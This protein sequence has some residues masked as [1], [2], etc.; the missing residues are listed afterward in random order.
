MECPHCFKSVHIQLDSGSEFGT[1]V[2][3]RVTTISCG[4]DGDSSFVFEKTVCPACTR[5]MFAMTIYT[6]RYNH[7]ASLHPADYDIHR[8]Q[9]W[10]RSS[11][12]PPVP[13]EVPDEYK[14]DYLEACLILNDSPRASAALSRGCLQL[15]LREK[16]GAEGKDLYNQIGWVLDNSN[17]P[18]SIAE[19]L[20]V[21]R[22]VG[23]KAAHPKLD[24]A[25]EI[26]PVE[27]WEAEWCLE[28]IEALY[29]HLF[30]M[31]A[32]NQARLKRMKRGNADGVA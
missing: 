6:A 13:P 20:D 17:L 24:N 32:K 28:V 14:A 29:D 23:N 30:V 7:P 1:D 3:G 5:L 10:P 4:R 26:V 18:S 25:G 12:R 9:I 8:I 31:P 22:V 27:P 15:L 21:P 19:L 2:G 16:L 11:G